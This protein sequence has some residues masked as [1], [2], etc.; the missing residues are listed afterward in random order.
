SL[1]KLLALSAA[2]EAAGLGDAPWPPNYKKQQGEPPRV[3]PS[4]AKSSKAKAPAKA[5]GRQPKAPLITV[6]KAEHKDDA[7]AG[8]ERWK[9]RH[10][11][12]AKHLAIDDILVDAM[13]GRST[14]WTRV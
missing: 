3:Q 9:S 7:L 10:P 6:S 14:T 1:D 13:R 8:L 11:D 2:H 4:K 12:A 5:K